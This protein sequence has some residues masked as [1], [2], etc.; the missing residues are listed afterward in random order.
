MLT[1][2]CESFEFIILNQKE[3]KSGLFEKTSEAV[4]LS[5]LPQRENEP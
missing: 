4:S 3:A 2:C 1:P 5:Q